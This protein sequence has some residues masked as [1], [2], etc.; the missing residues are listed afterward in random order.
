[1][2]GTSKRVLLQIAVS[3]ANSNLKNKKAGRHAYFSNKRVK[4]KT[5][6]KGNLMVGGRSLVICHQALSGAVPGTTTVRYPWVPTGR[7]LWP[8]RLFSLNLETWTF[9]FSSSCGPLPLYSALCLLIPSCIQ[10]A[11][12]YYPGLSSEPVPGLLAFLALADTHPR[13]YGRSS[14]FPKI[15]GGRAQIVLVTAGSYIQLLLNFCHP[16]TF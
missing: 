5:L 15:S 4:E 14:T 7:R 3:F 8:P 13:C 1:M 9:Q 16:L 6:E 10:P 2:K 12:N 11:H